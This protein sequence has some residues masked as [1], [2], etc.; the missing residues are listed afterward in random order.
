MGTMTTDQAADRA[1]KTRLE[2]PKDRIAGLMQNWR[3]DATSGFIVFLIALPL[4]L[5]IAIASGMPPLSGIFAAIVGGLVVSQLNGSF[6]TINGPAAGLIVVILGAVEKLGG[7][8][9]GYHATLAAIAISG[10]LLFIMGLL[11][12]G[13]LGNFFPGTVV[14]GMLASIGI[15][16]MSKQLPFVLGVKPPAKEPLQLIAKIPQMFT[17]MNPQIAMIGFTCLAILIIHAVI[18]NRTIKKIPAAII[19]VAISVAMGFMFDLQ[20]A[21]TYMLSGHEFKIDPK[22][23]VLLPNSILSGITHPDWSQISSGVFWSCIVSITLVQGI[24]TLL[25]CAAVDKLDTYKRQSNL[26]R[27]VAAVGL[28]SAVSAMIGGLPMIAEIV[29]SSANV[30]NGAKTRWANFFHG[31]F[32]LVFVLVGAQLVD[33]I[34]LAALAALLVFTGYRL[35]APKVFTETHKI[36]PEQTFL[37]VVTII[38]TLA[39]DLLIGVGTGIFCKF[40]LHLIKGAEPQHLFSVKTDVQNPS[41]DTYVVLVQSAAIF[42]NFIS[43]NRVLEKIP[44]GKNITVDLSKSKLVSNKTAGVNATT[45]NRIHC[46]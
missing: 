32:M 44:K 5:G 33:Q 20:H 13:V 18:K 39:T 46:P 7:G 24:E 36:G 19:V 9:V 10:I 37:F 28:G 11:K 15:I 2:L 42:S 27:D 41:P 17:D 22:Y 1:T 23:L 3:S 45:A 43:L 38:T 8:D 34:P 6:V 40:V 21:H 25:S 29:R 30:S 31:T 4:S 26:S 16:I 35:A 12:A 14:H